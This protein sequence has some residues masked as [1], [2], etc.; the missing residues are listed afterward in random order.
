MKTAP[1]V[2]SVYFLNG[3][4]Y[5]CD[6]TTYDSRSNLFGYYGAQYNCSDISN[7]CSQYTLQIDTNG[8]LEVINSSN[9]KSINTIFDPNLGSIAVVPTVILPGNNQMSHKNGLNQ[10]EYIISSNKKFK[11]LLN[12]DGSLKYVYYIKSDIC[13]KQKNGRY[14]GNTVDNISGAAIYNI[15]TLYPEPDLCNISAGYVSGS[16]QLR[17]YAKE[18]YAYD[19]NYSIFNNSDI[20]NSDINNNDINNTTNT[21]SIDECRQKCNSMP[22]CGGFTYDLS[23]MCT[24]KSGCVSNLSI[25][26]TDPAKQ[27]TLQIRSKSLPKTKINKTFVSPDTYNSFAPFDSFTLTSDMQFIQMEPA[28]PTQITPSLLA[29]ETTTTKLSNNIINIEKNREQINLFTNKNKNKNNFQSNII[30]S[31]MNMNTID[32]MINDGDLINL[33]SK[34]INICLSVLAIGTVIFTIANLKK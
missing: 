4:L 27:K 26:P 15:P 31:M 24:I 20:N 16:G 22:N 29:D 6:S 14:T 7:N 13:R 9:N 10:G 23:N 19:E 25:I 30:E 1:P 33:Q 3:T 34:Y 21:N 28:P 2:V 8:K 17:P 32:A 12:M 18:S 11:I 5:A